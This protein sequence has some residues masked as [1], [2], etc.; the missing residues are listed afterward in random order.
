MSLPQPKIIHSYN[1][2]MG[3]V[4]IFDQFRG[5]YRVAFRKRVWY[6]PL[7]R[8]VR[9][10]SLVN[11]WLLYRKLKPTTQLSFLDE[12]VFGLLKPVGGPSRHV[13]RP[14]SSSGRYDGLNHDLKYGPTQRRCGVCKKNV[15]P[16]CTKCDVALHVECWI[17]WHT[18]N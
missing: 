16:M 3:G 13:P 1:N 17:K 4:D 15:R 9:N 5:K 12:I 18:N 10:A 7:F 11:G 8:F 6:Y 2:G 14:I